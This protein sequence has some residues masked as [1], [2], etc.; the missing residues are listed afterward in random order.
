MWMPRYLKLPALST[1]SSQMYNGRW[2]LLLFS[3][4]L[5]S[6][7][8]CPCWGWGCWSH[9]VTPDWPPPSYRPLCSHRWCILLLR[10]RPQTLGWCYFCWRQHSHRLNPYRVPMLVMVL[11]EA[12]FPILTDWGLPVR[13]SRSQSQMVWTSISAD[14]GA[15]SSN[16]AEFRTKQTGSHALKQQYNIRLLF[17][18]KTL[19]V[20]ISTQI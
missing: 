7:S 13:K 18:I 9:T 4:P 10:C 6:P 19:R 17:K 3:F 16:L 2:V 12:L 1:S 11:A 15:R 8:S 5:S 14:A 20:D